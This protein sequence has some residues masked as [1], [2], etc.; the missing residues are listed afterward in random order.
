[1]Y[2]ID[3]ISRAVHKQMR[4]REEANEGPLVAEGYLKRFTFVL[5]DDAMIGC[6]EPCTAKDKVRI[7][8]PPSFI[9]LCPFVK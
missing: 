6:F 5:K 4:K 2:V 3:A 1:L 7:H 9:S 8:F